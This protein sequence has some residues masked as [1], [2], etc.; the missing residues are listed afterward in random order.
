MPRATALQATFARGELSPQTKGRVDLPIYF[1]GCETLENFTTRPEGGAIR[2]S[3]TRFV[4]K[5]KYEGARYVRLIAI[6]IADGLA[7][8]LEVG[9][10]YIR[11]LRDHGWEVDDEDAVYELASPYTEDDLDDIKVTQSAEG[12]YLVHPAWAPR[13]LTRKGPADWTLAVLEFLD[14]HYLAANTN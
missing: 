2:R 14:G 10:E 8:V 4:R 11:F 12:V 7:Y 9:H 13:V 5:P 3:G 6:E 1:Q